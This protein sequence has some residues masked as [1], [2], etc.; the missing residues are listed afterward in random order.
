M[1]YPASRRV[2]SKYYTQ[3]DDLMVDGSEDVTFTSNIIKEP[4]DVNRAIVAIARIYIFSY[5]SYAT[6][7]HRLVSNYRK[8]DSDGAAP[9]LPPRLLPARR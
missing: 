7:L 8:L 4:L 6:P 3:R 1:D 2:L 9:L 5:A